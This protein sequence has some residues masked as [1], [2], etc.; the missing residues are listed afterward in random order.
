LVQESGATPIRCTYQMHPFDFSRFDYE[1]ILEE[2]WYRSQGLHLIGAPI[3]IFKR[4][5]GAQS[6]SF[7]TRPEPSS[8]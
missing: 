4:L 2:I 1:S 6:E 8:T 7:S 3:H 5:E